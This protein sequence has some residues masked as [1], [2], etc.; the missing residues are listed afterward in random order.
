MPGNS[1][2]AGLPGE[3][4]ETILIVDD[5][6]AVLQLCVSILK[7]ANFVVLEATSG[8]DAIKLAAEAFCAD[9]AGGDDQR[10]SSHS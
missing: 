6:E 7:R 2:V 8:D 10:R 3:K 5:I 1:T 9:E 4:L